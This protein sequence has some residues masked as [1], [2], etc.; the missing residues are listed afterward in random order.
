MNVIVAR[1]EDADNPTFLR[2]V[3]AY[4]SERTKELY[5]TEFKGMYIPAWE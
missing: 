1:T 5:K 2:I 4:Q 3:E